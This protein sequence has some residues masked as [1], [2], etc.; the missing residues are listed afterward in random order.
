MERKGPVVVVTLEAKVHKESKVQRVTRVLQVPVLVVQ[1]DLLVAREIVESLARMVPK[2]MLVH[3]VPKVQPVITALRVTEATVVPWEGLVSVARVETREAKDLK[4]TQVTQDPLVPRGM[5]A[6]VVLVVMAA[7]SES[8]ANWVVKAFVVRL[9]VSVVVVSKV[10]LGEL[11]ML[12]QV[13]KRVSRGP[14]VSVVPL[15]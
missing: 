13:D 9:V 12:V 3:L 6:C 1:Q 2:V 5:S 14:E 11:G 15:A 4:E 10:T 8:R 7:Q